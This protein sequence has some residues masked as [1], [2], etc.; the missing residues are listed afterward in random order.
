MFRMRCNSDASLDW[1]GLDANAAG[2]GESASG[3]ASR[4]VR[5]LDETILNSCDKQPWLM[6]VC[7]GKL[8]GTRLL[9]TSR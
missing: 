1:S 2:A 6:M 4:K 5:F 7:A 9:V 8:D 3:S